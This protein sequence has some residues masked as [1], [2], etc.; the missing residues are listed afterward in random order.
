M[1]TPHRDPADCADSL[2]KHVADQLKR[3]QASAQQQRGHSAVTLHVPVRGLLLSTLSRHSFLHADVAK[4]VHFSSH[5]LALA[6]KAVVRLLELTG[7]KEFNGVHL[8]IENDYIQQ[9]QITSGGQ[10]PHLVGSGL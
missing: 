6:D 4:N 8:R 3:R 10:P 2:K 5:L 9:N 7:A 1:K